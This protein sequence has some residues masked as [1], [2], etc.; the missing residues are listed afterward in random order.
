MPVN[1]S[2]LAAQHIKFVICPDTASVHQPVGHREKGGNGADIP[3]F[4]LG[5][6][7][8]VQRL[9]IGIVNFLRVGADLDGIV[10]HYA[11]AG[12]DIGLAIVHCDLIGDLRVL[13]ADPQDRAMNHHAILTLVD[14]AG[15]DDDQFALGLRRGRLPAPSARRDSQREIPWAGGPGPEDVGDEAGFLGHRTDAFGHIFGQVLES[16]LRESD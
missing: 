1:T 13:R 16:E 4:V 5:K 12:R 9:V 15:G 8:I 6:T 3:D 11:F 7:R 14:A 2:S 10:Q